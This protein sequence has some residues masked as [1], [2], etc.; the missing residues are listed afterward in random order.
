MSLTNM[1]VFNKYIQPAIIETL[2]VMIDK[3]NGAS[4]GAIRLTTEDCLICARL[5]ATCAALAA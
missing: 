4:R 2:A 3:F 5:V 1:Q